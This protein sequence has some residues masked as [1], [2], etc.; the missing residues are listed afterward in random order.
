VAAERRRPATGPVALAR[1]P[2]TTP[3]AGVPAVSHPAGSDTVEIE[4]APSYPEPPTYRT[5]VP[6]PVPL[7]DDAKFPR[8]GMKLPRGAAIPTTVATAPPRRR[9]GWL[10]AVATALVAVAA[11]IGVLA[12]TRSDAALPRD[13]DEP[14][15]LR[16]TR[17]PA[18]QTTAAGSA[19]PQPTP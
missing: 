1:R 18:A 5:R 16:M 13:R 4:P 12:A 14:P 19:A 2:L 9:R 8:P 15:V 3:P 7:H 10:I 17:I 11:V 6:L